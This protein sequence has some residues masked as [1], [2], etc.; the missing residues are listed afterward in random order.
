MN[1][2]ITFKIISSISNTLPIRSCVVSTVTDAKKTKQIAW[3]GFSI[4]VNKEAKIP[5]GINTLEL[6]NRIA[7]LVRD[8]V[9]EGIADYHEETN[10][11]NGV[12]IVVTLKKDANPNVVLNNLYKHTPL[13]STYGIIFLM[14]DKGVPKTFWASYIFSAIF[15]NY[16]VVFI[17]FVIW[18]FIVDG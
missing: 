1:P 17:V 3:N 16:N 2:P 7:E 5:Y 14:L 13:Q 6:K 15:I 18:F 4:L 9:L 11:E 8:K 12:K 10:I